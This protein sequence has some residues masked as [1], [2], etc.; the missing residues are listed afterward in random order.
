MDFAFKYVKDNKGIDTEASYPYT[1][2]TGETPHSSQQT[3][4]KN[5][6]QIVLLG[7]A[8]HDYFCIRQDVPVQCDQLWGQPHLLD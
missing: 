8:S 1:A 6:Q 7:K 5:T 4:A 2:K 3:D